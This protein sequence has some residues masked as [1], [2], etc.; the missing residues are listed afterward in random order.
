VVGS[1]NTNAGRN[2]GSGNSPITSDDIK[3]RIIWALIA[4]IA[5]G[6]GAASYVNL[7]P[8]RPDPFTGTQ[9]NALERRIAKLETSQALD[10]QHR[11]DAVDGYRR[12]RA[13]E[14][15]CERIHE[16]LNGLTWRFGNGS[17]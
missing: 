13:T 4:I 9:G 17:K 8:Q 15:C 16:K 1:S 6:G 12:M 5:G 2:N 3:L 10:D 14:A 11:I 7:N